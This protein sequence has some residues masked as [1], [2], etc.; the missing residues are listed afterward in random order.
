MDYLSKHQYQ[1]SQ[2]WL[3]I[4]PQ[5]KMAGHS[6]WQNIKSTKEAADN[7]HM[8]MVQSYVAQMKAAITGM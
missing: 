2:Q 7:K 5:R 3:L 1:C 4:V 6:H 8:L